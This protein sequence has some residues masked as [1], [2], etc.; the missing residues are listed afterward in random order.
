MPTQWSSYP[1][2]F[3]G[4]LITSMTKLEQ[5]TKF[6][7]SAVALINYEVSMKGGY[8][9][10]AGFSKFSASSPNGS[11]DIVGAIS[12]NLTDVLARRGDVYSISSGTTWTTKS[13][14]AIT[15]ATRIR[16]DVFNFDG[17]ETVVIVDG[18]EDPAFFDVATETMTYDTSAPADVTGATI[19][20]VFNNSL[21]FAKGTLLN[22]TAPFDETDY[23]TGNGAGVINI[24]DEITGLI[25]FRQELIV[26]CRDSIFKISG[27]SSSDFVLSTITRKT[28]CLSP[29]SIVE[30][31]GD[32]LYLGPDGVR[33]LGATER[34]NDFALERAS[35]K[36]YS[37]LVEFSNSTGAIVALPIR[38]K[39]QYR[40]FDY[41]SVSAPYSLGYA[42]T[43]ISNQGFDDVGWSKLRGIKVWSVDSK[44]YASNEVIIF[45][46][47]TAYVYLME[48]GSDFDGENIVSVFETPQFV[49]TDPR[50]R[51]TLYKHTLYVT[52]SGQLTLKCRVKLD[53][54]KSGS[55]Q[56]SVF[57]V[58]DS[59]AS[60]S[61][62]G[63]AIYGTSVYTANSSKVYTNNIVGSGLSFSLNYRTNDTS[64]HHLEYVILE[65]SEN[66][67][68]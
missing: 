41:T 37:E 8:E 42:M 10:I 51:K 12:Y 60:G 22:F 30:L 59:F 61:L 62:Y 19:V 11:G 55:I 13:T 18:F 23:N 64:S 49:I 3:E 31:G 36:V 9:K 7:G 46:G 21:F 28:G 35:D 15:G 29:D 54:N 39:N 20:K 40:I 14:V 58:E 26:F 16:H 43:K 67:R 34:I 52:M 63:T 32:I 65:Y 48:S 44:Q 57:L 2:K 38:R 1:I 56:P 53:Y 45:T 27:T 24:G 68:R 50:V 47:E 25:V 6:P 66:E 33:W 4:G 5:G 17:N